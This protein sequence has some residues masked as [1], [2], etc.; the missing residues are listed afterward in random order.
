VGC[1]KVHIQLDAKW[2]RFQEDALVAPN[3]EQFSFGVGGYV[4]QA[5]QEWND[6]VPDGQVLV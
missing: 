1:T 3:N 5:S 6:N 4:K 2:F